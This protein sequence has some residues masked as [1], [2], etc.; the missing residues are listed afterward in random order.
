MTAPL[1]KK[2]EYEHDILIHYMSAIDLS[3]VRTVGCIVFTAHK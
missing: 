2:N 3:M 1:Q